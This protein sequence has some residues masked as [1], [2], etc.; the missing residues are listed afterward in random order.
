MIRRLEGKVG[1]IVGGTRGIGK[2]I[3]LR[4]ARLGMDL[5]VLARSEKELEETGKEI[6]ALGVK[7]LTVRADASDY[8]AFG[9]AY[10]KVWDTFGRFDL[11]VNS[12]GTGVMTPFE[13]LT[14]ED[15]DTTIDVNLKGTIY[16]IRQAVDYMAR[17]GG[18]NILNI[19]SMSAIRGIPD[20]VN[21]NGIYTATKFAVNGFTECMQKYLLKYNIRVTALCPGST[22]TSW[23]T[24]WTHSFGTDAMLPADTLADM[25][26]MI[27]TAPE[28]VLFKQMQVLPTVEIDNF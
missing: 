10:Q 26:E 6:T 25:A 18:G 15:I 19:S 7:C 27:V 12:A 1:V 21:C 3:A 11:L 4:M 24:R 14:V 9:E 17:S 8:A 23:W 2:A 22:A 28:K 20:P 16:S 13:E 5:A